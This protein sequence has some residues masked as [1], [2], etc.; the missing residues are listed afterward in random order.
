MIQA[1]HTLDLL[2][3]VLGMP[4]RV[5]GRTA[6]AVHPIEV[7]DLAVGILEWENGATAVLQVT[8]GVFPENPSELEVHGEN[9][10][11]ALFESRGYLGYWA[12]LLDK[13]SSLLDRWSLYASH[14]H[15]QDSTLPSQASPE[16]HAENIRDFVAA[17]RGGRSPLVDGVEA[18]KVLLLVDA[19]YRSAASGTW[20]EL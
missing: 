3:W 11:A 13:P 4:R 12:S 9:G 18:R 10:T 8:T 7:E 16:P 17:V 2:Q 6:T 14:F 5:F 19:L 15:E 1:I 20:V